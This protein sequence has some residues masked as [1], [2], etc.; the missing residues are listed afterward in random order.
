LKKKVKFTGS[1]KHNRDVAKTD[2][3]T[4]QSFIAYKSRTTTLNPKTSRR[5][6]R[7]GMMNAPKGALYGCKNCGLRIDRQ[8]NAAI[9][10]HLQMKALTPS[11]RLFD[12][13]MKA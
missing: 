2:W 13:L 10:L 6:S 3:K 8:L 11:P 1:R 12:G 5:C 7:C 4:I 9:N